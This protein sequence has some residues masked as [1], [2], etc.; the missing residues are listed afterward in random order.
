MKA[1]QLGTQGGELRIN[2]YRDGRTRLSLIGG[3]SIFPAREAEAARWLLVD[4]QAGPWDS[5]APSASQAP[6]RR[7]R[8]FTML[9]A[10]NICIMDART[11]VPR[12]DPMLLQ[13]QSCRHSGDISCSDAESHGSICMVPEH[14]GYRAHLG[15][16][17]GASISSRGGRNEA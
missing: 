13:T 4:A 11:C 12:I 5:G 8:C 1:L 10:L 2:A 16:H 6:A 9:V 3:S 7:W 14:R 17:R 15:A